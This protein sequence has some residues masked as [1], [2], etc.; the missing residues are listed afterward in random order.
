MTKKGNTCKNTCHIQNKMLESVQAK[1][2]FASLFYDFY[3]F[4]H[5]ASVS[6]PPIVGI[7]DVGY[8]A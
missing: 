3:G 1:I 8:A 7:F 6:L 4:I 2:L 5:S